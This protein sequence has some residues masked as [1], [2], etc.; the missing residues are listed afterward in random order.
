MRA[1]SEER[2]VAVRWII[3]L[4]MKG[5]YSRLQNPLLWLG[6]DDALE[7]LARLNPRKAQVV[8]LRY[9][10]GLSVEEAAE[11]LGVHPNTVINDWS[12]AKGLAEARTGSRGR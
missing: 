11:V 5:W 10:G 1:G 2:S 3:C 12:F 9:F 8:E 7:D 4:W 6:L